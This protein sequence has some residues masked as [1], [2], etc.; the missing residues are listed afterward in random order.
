MVKIY[1]LPRELNLTDELEPWQFQFKHV[2]FPVLSMEAMEADLSRS[3]LDEIKKVH[4]LKYENQAKHYTLAQ[5]TK[6][7]ELQNYRLPWLRFSLDNL[8]LAAPV[9]LLSELFS[10]YFAGKALLNPSLYKLK[11]GAKLASRIFS[12]GFVLLDQSHKMIVGDL[13]LSHEVYEDAHLE[14]LMLGA[15]LLACLCLASEGRSQPKEIV[16]LAV[17][18]KK[19]NL[20]THKYDDVSR[21]RLRQQRCTSRSLERLKKLV[22]HNNDLLLQNRIDQEKFN[23]LMQQDS[24]LI[25]SVHEVSWDDLLN[26]FRDCCVTENRFHLIPSISELQEAC[27]GEVQCSA[28]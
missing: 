13:H 10:V 1:P 8:L 22:E 21:F 18:P 2:T 23:R 7:D 26:R 25:L 17:T 20:Q 16:Y 4:A 9:N 6:L 24:S 15:Y 14:N 27:A 19:N 5:K 28:S 12:P 3:R 11:S